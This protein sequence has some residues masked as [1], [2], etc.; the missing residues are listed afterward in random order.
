MLDRLLGSDLLL[1]LLGGIDLED[2]MTVPVELALDE[3][4]DPVVIVLLHDVFEVVFYES[5]FELFGGPI[6]TVVHAISTR[7]V[8]NRQSC[9]ERRERG[10]E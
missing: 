7:T 6:A 10:R 4:L 9:G 3:E 5:V 2:E 1:L 8:R